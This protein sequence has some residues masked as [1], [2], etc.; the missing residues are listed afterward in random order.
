LGAFDRIG[1]NINGRRLTC[2]TSPR[3][4][5]EWPCSA[6]TRSKRPAVDDGTRDGGALPCALRWT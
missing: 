6:H 3:F 5:S 1:E 2:L 4:H